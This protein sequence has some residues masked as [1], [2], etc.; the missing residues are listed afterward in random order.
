MWFC[1]STNHWNIFFNDLYHEV[2]IVCIVC[3]VS[4]YKLQQR[5]KTICQLITGIPITLYYFLI[6]KCTI[7]YILVKKTIDQ[8]Y[9]YYFTNI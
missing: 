3:N 4:L 7:L 8:K 6:T 1:S 9:K 2:S 5:S